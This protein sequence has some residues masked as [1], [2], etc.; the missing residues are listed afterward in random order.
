MGEQKTVLVLLSVI[1]SLLAVI[2]VA[3]ASDDDFW[4]SLEP[5]PTARNNLGVR[6]NRI[7][8]STL[9]EVDFCL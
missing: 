5:M 3:E 1:F 8:E 6:L 4:V 9:L 2:P 7:Y